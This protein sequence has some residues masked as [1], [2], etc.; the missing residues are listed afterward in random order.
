MTEI[1]AQKQGFASRPV[2]ELN[3]GQTDAQVAYLLRG[4]D[5]T[6]YFTP[7]HIAMM[8]GR[9]A[10][11]EKPPPTA[12][13]KAPAQ[14]QW[15]TW[16]LR[17]RFVGAQRQPLIQGLERLKATKNYFAGKDA[18]TWRSNIPT[19]DKIKYS[20][21]Y[22]GIDLVFYWSGEQ[23][24]FDFI[25]APGG[26]PQS[27]LLEF[28][29]AD[30]ISVNEDG[31]LA[32][33]VYGHQI[34]LRTPFIYQM[35][36]GARN[37]IDGG[38]RIEEP[39][40]VGFELR[41]KYE[42]ALPLVID[43]VLEYSTYLG[44]DAFTQGNGI[45]VDASGNAYVTGRT[46]ATNF[47]NDGNI[48]PDYGG[49]TDAFITKFSAAGNTLIYSTY[50]GGSGFDEGNSIA[51]DRFS[52]VYVTGITYSTDFPTA[53]AVQPSAPPNANAFVTSLDPTGSALNYST[54]LGGDGDDWGVGIAVDSSGNAYIAGNTA[55]DNFPLQNALQSTLPASNSVFVTKLASMG[56][57]ILYSTYFGGADS[58]SA[59]GI[60]VDG[61]T[62]MYITGT[63]GAGLPL[64]NPIQP[65]FGG[66]DSD[67]YTAK[68]D[69]SGAALLYST[70][71]GG[72]GDDAGGGIA[73]DSYGNA[74]VT[75]STPSADFPTANAVQPAIGGGDDAFICKINP[76]GSAFIFST[77]LGGSSDEIGTGIATDPFANTY[78]TGVTDS[79][80][81]PLAHPLQTTTDG[82]DVYISKF[83]ATGS[84]IYSTYLGGSNPDAGQ[85]I[86]ADFSGNAY[87]TGA[88]TS[89]NFPLENP[90]QSTLEAIPA[91]FVSK[92]V[93]DIAVGP[94]GPTGPAGPTG[95]TGSPG[96]TGAD[97]PVGAT[98]PAGPTGASGAVGPA[99]ATGSDGAMGAMGLPGIPGATG[100]SGTPGPGGP[101]GA[102]GPAGRNGQRGPRGFRGPA[103]KTIK[104]V[105]I[106][107]ICCCGKRNQHKCCKKHPKKHRSRSRR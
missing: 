13:A 40:M 10:Q 82:A 56:A 98:G 17:M 72:S 38:Y 75:G 89:F 15:E 105:K 32:V 48:Q 64:A 63:T 27:I 106:I 28:E 51:V 73:V 50:L 66:G 97:G 31:N 65:L 49:S 104:I 19:F 18:A 60:A 87:V 41:G 91:A 54:Y 67:A 1:P 44:A 69:A 85:S 33:S 101:T 36:D 84:F 46:M 42:A 83:N 9:P 95:A 81:F 45:A 92:I 107:R 99:G 77:F 39:G 7:S 55:S 23:L 93:D 12:T 34:R 53:S 52:N 5:S 20:G 11:Q 80:N 68:I 14:K 71:L 57:S 96:V 4:W 70:Y 59:G 2:F 25:L 94:T 37:R 30:E 43:P 3:A 86:A 62:N 90:Y 103:G 29:G 74:Y 102:S 35:R 6:L 76:A 47:P 22:P 88:T 79:F 24:E 8:F 100:A 58:T 61:F 78:V 21:L 16:G 26:D